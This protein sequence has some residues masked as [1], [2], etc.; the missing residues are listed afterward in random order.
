M[1]QKK[2][3]VRGRHSFC[4][5]Y[6]AGWREQSQWSNISAEPQISRYLTDEYRYQPNRSGKI[7]DIQGKDV[8]LEAPA[9]STKRLVGYTSPFLQG[10]KLLLRNPYPLTTVAG[11][12]WVCIQEFQIWRQRETYGEEAADWGPSESTH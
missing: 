11:G 9:R 12:M 10:A 8:N 1:H 3:I 7:M 5:S 2:D 4:L 6:L